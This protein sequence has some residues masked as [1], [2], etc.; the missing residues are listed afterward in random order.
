MRAMVLDK[1][2]PIESAPLVLREIPAPVPGQGEVRVRVSVCALCRT[3]LHVIE[4]DLPPLKSPIIPGHQAVGYVDAIGPGSRR[5][6]EGQRIGIAWLRYTDGTCIYCSR[7][8][9]NLCPNS[10]YTGYMEDG[11]YAE[12]AVVPE[13]FAY[14][15]PQGLSDAEISPLLCGGL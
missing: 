14:P 4:G 11:G 2:A 13:E 1:Q 12:Y 5:F 3:D 7:G 10:R 8:S 9:E 15:L 6:K